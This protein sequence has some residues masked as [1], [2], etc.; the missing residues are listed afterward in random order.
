MI[1]TTSDDFRYQTRFTNGTHSAVS[2]TTKDKGGSESG[3]RPH[4]LLEAALASC[5][6]MTLRMYA[7]QHNI[8]LSGVTTRVTL[9][10]T[11]PVET[12]FEYGIELHG[13]LSQDHRDRLLEVA[14]K[15]P[16]RQTLSKSI[17]FR[18]R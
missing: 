5:I 2:D 1:E 7:D 4:D 17:G 3:F 16:V 12:V 11:H 14:K 13:S 6:N 9:D 8:P 15:C 18:A 10:R